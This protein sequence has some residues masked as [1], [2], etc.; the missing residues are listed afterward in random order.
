MK[1]RNENSLMEMLVA[2]AATCNACMSACLDE[3]DVRKMRVCIE[4]NLDC[5]AI[6][7]LTASYLSRSSKFAREI[8][9]LCHTICIACA[10][11]CENHT[12]NHCRRCAAI[13]RQCAEQCMTEDI[14]IPV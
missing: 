3:K 1:I 6:C 4:L 9:P 10:E 2:C 13:C 5:A 12:E 8:L 7:N 11:E 14:L